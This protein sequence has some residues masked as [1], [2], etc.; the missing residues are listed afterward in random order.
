MSTRSSRGISPGRN[1]HCIEISNT[2][3]YS[4][5]W[6]DSCDTIIS[7]LYPLLHSGDQISPVFIRCDVITLLLISLDFP[8]I[9][10]QTN[11]PVANVEID[12]WNVHRHRSDLY[13]KAMRSLRSLPCLCLCAS[14]MFTPFS[15]H[16]KASIKPKAINPKGNSDYLGAWVARLRRSPVQARLP[17]RKLAD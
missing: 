11:Q 6:G 2:S 16:M 15:K 1:I 3:W 13:T 4:P 17:Q 8:S 7:P 14:H 10:N 9:I 5:E 12:M